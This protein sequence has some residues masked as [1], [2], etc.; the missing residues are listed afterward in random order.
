MTY[1][2]QELGA[3]SKEQR[4]KMLKTVNMRDVNQ[5][6]YSSTSMEYFFLVPI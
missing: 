4:V 5:Y 3:Q 1:D 2:R 6:D